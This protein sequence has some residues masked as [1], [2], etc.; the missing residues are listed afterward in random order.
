MASLALV[1]ALAAPTPWPALAQDA[2]AQGAEAQAVEAQGVEPQPEP[3]VDANAPAAGAVGAAASRHR[4]HHAASN[5]PSQE[6]PPDPA[7]SG[8][9]A[10]MAAWVTHAGDNGARPF[11][12]VDKLAAEVFVFDADGQL[13][14][15]AP[16][17]VGLAHG[18]DSPAG[19]GDKALAA[20]SPDERTTPAGRFV[21][22]FGPASGGKTVI[23]VDYA[24]AISLHPV[25]TTNPKEHRL[26]RIKSSAPEDHRISFGCINVPARFYETVVLKAFAGGS[27]IVYI[28]PDTRPLQDV[29]PAFA[30]TTQA[31]AVADD[32][33]TTQ[34][35]AVVDYADQAAARPAQFDAAQAGDGRPAAAVELGAGSDQAVEP[36][37]DPDRAVETQPAQAAADPAAADPPAA[38]PPAKKSPQHAHRRHHVASPAP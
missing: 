1:L 37:A 8:M 21:A 28:L 38:P 13:L 12:I 3:A 20:I 10:Q 24:D 27:A 18:D 35:S 22:G 7:L 14:G 5:Q 19:V 29:F 25:V 31:S 32:A 30:S 2:A 15:G 34:A 26:T 4:R 36:T 16:V 11:A 33:A 17:L 23:W 6:V 9:A